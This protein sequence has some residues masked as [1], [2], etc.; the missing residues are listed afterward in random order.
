MNETLLSL[1]LHLKSGFT[2]RDYIYLVEKHGCVETAVKKESIPLSSELSLAS[3]E[4]EKAE[5]LGVKVIPLCSPEYPKLLRH[6]QNPPI[7]IYLKGE[8]PSQPCVAVVGA[9]RC[10]AYGRKVAYKIACF[11]AKKGVCTVSGLAYGVDTYAHKGAVECAGKTVA[12]FGTGVDVVYPKANEPLAERIVKTGGALISEFPLGTQPSRENF[13]L[14][15]R[16]VSG[17]SYAVVV[18]EAGE[19]SGTSITVGYALEQGRLVFAVPGNI[20]SEK[21]KGTNRFIKEGAIPLLSPGDI[22]EDL[23]RVVEGE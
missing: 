4:L 20:D 18:V 19:R 3:K 11:L 15:N 13:P 8:L 17:L 9:R 2:A 5:K 16:I 10:T 7:V 14:R 1:A 21:S 22:I 6:I 12:V 23:S